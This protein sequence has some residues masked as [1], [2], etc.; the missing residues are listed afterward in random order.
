MIYAVKMVRHQNT[1]P[2]EVVDASFQEVFKA[3]LYGAL[4]MLTWC[5]VSLPMA[6][7]L[8]LIEFLWS[9]AIKTRL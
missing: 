8:E 3:W 2:R 7:E 6:R 4:N 1:L 9:L 5:E